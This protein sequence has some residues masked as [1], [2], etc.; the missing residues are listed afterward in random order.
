MIARISGKLID[1]TDDAV[2][3]Q[4]NSITYKLSI[5]AC[6]F[7]NIQHKIGN[8]IEFFTLYYLEGQGQGSNYRPRLIGF[9]SQEDLDFFECF[10]KVKGVGPKKALRAM[11]APTSQIALAISEGNISFLVSTLSFKFLKVPFLI[12]DS[13]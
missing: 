12:T 8:Q 1:V 4:T 9:Q 3:I 10:T 6:D 7:P 11:T 13:T 5:P 2:L